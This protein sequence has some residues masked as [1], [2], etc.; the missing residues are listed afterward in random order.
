ML[1]KQH[2]KKNEPGNN[3]AEL[4]DY[5]LSRHESFDEDFGRS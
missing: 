1:D 2:R 3:T 5:G 4:K